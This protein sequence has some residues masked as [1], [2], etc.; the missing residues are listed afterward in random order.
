MSVVV[1]AVHYLPSG[2]PWGSISWVSTVGQ[3]TRKGKEY[4]THIH[5]PHFS[6]SFSDLFS[7]LSGDPL[8]SIF[9][10][11]TPPW[12]I[13]EGEEQSFHSYSQLAPPMDDLS[14]LPLWWS[15]WESLHGETLEVSKNNFLGDLTDHFSGSHDPPM[16]HRPQFGNQWYRQRSQDRMKTRSL[17]WTEEQDSQLYGDLNMGVPYLIHYTTLSQCMKNIP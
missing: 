11:R 7:A 9:Q 5:N 2:G 6:A 15:I 1:W 10:V 14:F 17:P 16:D 3:T 8:G 12:A 4:T 13:R